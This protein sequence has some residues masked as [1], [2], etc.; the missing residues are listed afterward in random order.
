MTPDELYEL[1][2]KYESQ[3]SPPVPYV[4]VEV[5]TFNAATGTFSGLTTKIETDP[6]PIEHGPNQVPIQP[7]P[8]FLG[9][10]WYSPQI[11]KLWRTTTTITPAPKVPLA[12]ILLKF[13]ITNPRPEGWGVT[14]NG[15]TF[16]ARAGSSTLCVDIWDDTVVAWQVSSGAQSYSDRIMLQHPS[17]SLGAPGAV[18]AFTIPFLPVAIVYAPPAD[19][20]GQSSASYLESETIGSSSTWEYKTESSTTRPVTDTVYGRADEFKGFVDTIGGIAKDSQNEYAKIFASICQEVS[21]AIGKVDSQIVS[22]IADLTHEEMTVIETA[23][24]GLATSAKI[25]GPGM[26][27]Q[28]SYLTNVRMAWAYYKGQLRLTLIGAGKMTISASSLQTYINDPATTRLLPDDAKALLAFDPFVAGGSAAALSP[29]RFQLVTPNYEYVG[30][31]GAAGGSITFTQ[32]CTRSS[33]MQ[34]THVSYTTT[35]NEWNP[36]FLLSVF[37]VDSQE[38]ATV[39]VSSAHND[40]LSKTISI[41][42]QL[43]CG[44]DEHFAFNLYQDLLFGT[45][46]FQMIPT[47]KPAKFEG[48]GAGAGERITLKTGTE[49]FTTVADQTGR[50]AFHNARIA[51]GQAVLKIGDQ[52]EKTVRIGGGSLPGGP[53]LINGSGADTSSGGLAIVNG[54]GADNVTSHAQV[55]TSG[56]DM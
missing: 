50:F 35:L 33:S 15:S 26:G 46:A 40:S 11:D 16:T 55:N 2:K 43:A 34:S 6:E 12:P 29:D 9:E 30:V 7:K 10:L 20:L 31:G 54:S 37:G 44:A 32:S 24:S 17:G 53:I 27:D 49:V 42:A 48:Q 1:I 8:H 38:K 18:G 14:V 23:S 4:T 19:S 45:Y 47:T 51:D 22:G 25:G 52:P 13:S 36:G 5:G 28:I 39:T 41:K 21:S 56:R 3:S